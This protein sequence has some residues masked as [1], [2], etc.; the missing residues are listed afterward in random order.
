MFFRRIFEVFRREKSFWTWI[1]GAPYRLGAALSIRIGFRGV[2]AK[3]GEKINFQKK[4]FKKIYNFQPHIEKKEQ[5][6]GFFEK[7]FIDFI[8]QELDVSH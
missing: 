2:G 1:W 5:N 6:L 4:V 8:K 7:T 3:T